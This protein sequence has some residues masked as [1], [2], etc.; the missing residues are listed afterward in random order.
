MN[1]RRKKRGSGASDSGRRRRK[2]PF[3]SA[4]R[5]EVDYKDTETLLK[6]VTERGKILPRRITGVC[7]LMHRRLVRA[8]ERARYMALLP[9]VAED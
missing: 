1:G 3:M 6:F 8:I 7:A 4:K 9:Y 5:T 2:C